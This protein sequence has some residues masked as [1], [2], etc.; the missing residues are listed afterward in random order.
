MFIDCNFGVY[1]RDFWSVY[2]DVALFSVSANGAYS[3]CETERLS[4]CPLPADTDQSRKD[5]PLL[6]PLAV[7]YTA[8][9]MVPY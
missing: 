7:W 2:S 6:H 5:L 4:L 9:P 1:G 3:L 8:E